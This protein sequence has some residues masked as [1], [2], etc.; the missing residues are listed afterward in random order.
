MKDGNGGCEATNTTILGCRC[1]SCPHDEEGDSRRF[2]HN[3]PHCR[4]LGGLPSWG[5]LP[6]LHQAPR[7]RTNQPPASP[8]RCNPPLPS[9]YHLS[10]QFI[11]M[12]IFHPSP[13]SF[14]AH[15]AWCAL[16]HYYSFFIKIKPFFFRSSSTVDLEPPSLSHFAHSIITLCRAASSS[17]D[18][19]HQR[20]VP[21]M[22]SGIPL[23]V[24]PQSSARA[25]QTRARSAQPKLR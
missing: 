11:L 20:L 25:H 23:H 1:R 6:P 17:I 10:S 7:W 3:H 12:I 8:I 22:Q 13:Q 4:Q 14:L 5:R 19:L 21:N 24:E 15:H 9:I 18:V 2:D 16:L